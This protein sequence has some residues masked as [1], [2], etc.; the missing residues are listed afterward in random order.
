MY[1]LATELPVYVY[2]LPPSVRGSSLLHRLNHA[3]AFH[4]PPILPGLQLLRD[5]RG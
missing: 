4:P 3:S 2:L 1:P 5:P